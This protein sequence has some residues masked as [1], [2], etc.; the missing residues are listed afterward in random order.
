MSEMKYYI[1]I[2]EG[3]TDCSLLEVIVEKFLG[4]QSFTN[5]KEL[6]ELF[7]QMIGTY[8]SYGGELRRQDSPTFYYRDNIGIAIKQANG[9][10]NIPERIQA[11][12]EIVEKEDIYEQFGGFLVF[13]D[14]D[15]KC[16]EEILEAF[17]NSFRQNDMSYEGEILSAY[18]QNM[19]CKVHLFPENGSGAVEKLLLECANVTYGHLCEIAGVFKKDIMEAEFED[20]RNKCWAKNTKIQEFYA[21]KVQFGAISTVL[22]PDR[23]VRFTIK[24]KIFHRKDLE[25]YDA[26]PEFKALYKFLESN[27]M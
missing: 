12:V 13:C 16:K 18:N 10:S 24:D 11:L 21:D 26:L 20:I 19:N 5:I 15:L 8:P 27:L 25:K 17:E 2:S 9:C 14:T 6:P 22:K 3:V 7:K 1:L 23:P 4:F